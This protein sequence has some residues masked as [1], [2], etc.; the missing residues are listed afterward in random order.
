[1]SPHSPAMDPLRGL[2]HPDPL[3][4]S[5]DLAKFHGC[6]LPPIRNGFVTRELDRPP[7]TSWIDLQQASTRPIASW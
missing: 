2:H 5:S 7:I 6:R 1:M 4:P 3:R